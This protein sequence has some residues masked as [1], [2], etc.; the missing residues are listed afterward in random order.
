MA[1]RQAIGAPSPQNVAAQLRRWNEIG[2]L[3]MSFHHFIQDTA[4]WQTSGDVSFRIRSG[5]SRNRNADA[6]APRPVRGRCASQGACVVAP[7]TLDGKYLLVRQERI[8]IREAS[9][10]FP[11]GRSMKIRSH[12]GRD[13]RPACA[14]CARKPATNSRRVAK[15]SPSAI[16]SSAGFTDEHSHLLLAD[17]VS[18]GRRPCAR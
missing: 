3:R 15:S 8:P 7:R 4:G 9:G 17:A 10:N 12:R 6:N 11:P 2:F 16:F 18:R 13:P 14:N 1:A 5:G